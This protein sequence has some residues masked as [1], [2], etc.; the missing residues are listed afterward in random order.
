MRFWLE[1]G[2]DG[3]RLDVI[4]FYFHSKGLEDNP[5]LHEDHR[6]NSIAPSVNPYNYQDHLYDKS[7][8]ENLDFLRRFRALLD[9]YPGTTAVGEVG[10]A[11]RGLDIV[12]AYTAGNERVHMCYA[13]D[14][15]QPMKIIRAERTARAG[16][17]RD[18]GADRLVVL[19]V[20]QPRRDAARLA[21]GRRRS[22]SGRLQQD[23]LGAPVFAARLGLPLPGRGT[24]PAGSRTRL[25][26]PARSL[27]YP[28]LAGI[29]R[30]RRMPH[31]DGL[32]RRR[33]CVRFLRGRAMAARLARRMVRFR[34]AAQV[35]RPDSMLEHY[36]RLLAFRRQ[37]KALVKGSITFLVAEGD[38]LVFERRDA[39]ERMLCA[40]NLG[41]GWVSLAVEDLKLSVLDEHGFAGTYEKGEIRLGPYGAFFALIES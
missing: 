34:S 10:D 37:H 8:P 15:L 31:A 9:E 1:R 30:P 11:Q 12:A 27:W 28:L 32:G 19:G 35:G 18:G 23:R 2:V 41:S 25:R 29:S 3:F 20:F 33:P 16:G 40:F 4:N 26:G 17:I 14:F 5:P 6:N 13:F 22:R 21:L 24:G 39:E 36:R 38:A 7:Q